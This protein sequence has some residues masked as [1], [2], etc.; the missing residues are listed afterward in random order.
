MYSIAVTVSVNG[1]TAT[2]STTPAIAPMPGDALLVNHEWCEVVGVS[3]ST[4]TLYGP[5]S[6]GN[7]TGPAT[8]LQCASSNTTPAL[9]LRAEYEAGKLEQ[10]LGSELIDFLT[11]AQSTVDIHD[12]TLDEVIVRQVDSAASLISRLPVIA[13]IPTPDA[14]PRASSQGTI[15][16]DWFNTPSLPIKGAGSSVTSAAVGPVPSSSIKV[17]AATG[18]NIVTL[19]PNVDRPSVVV[20]SNQDSLCLELVAPTQPTAESLLRSTEF[21]VLLFP[22]VKLKAL[23]A[24]NNSVQALE[25]VR[26]ILFDRSGGVWNK[27]SAWI[28]RFVYVEGGFKQLSGGWSL[29]MARGPFKLGIGPTDPGTGMTADG[30]TA[31]F[32]VDPAIDTFDMV[33]VDAFFPTGQRM[34]VMDIAGSPADK[35]YVVPFFWGEFISTPP[36]GYQAGAPA[37]SP[38]SA[39][40]GAQYSAALASDDFHPGSIGVNTTDPAGSAWFYTDHLYWQKDLLPTPNAGMSLEFLFGR[41][42]LGTQASYDRALPNTP[43]QS[44][45]MCFRANG[46]GH[47]G[48]YTGA[49]D[50]FGVGMAAADAVSGAWLQMLHVVDG[51]GSGHSLSLRLGNLTEST[52]DVVVNGPLIQATDHDPDF[53]Q[54][55]ILCVSEES[56]GQRAVTLYHNGQPGQTVQ[57]SASLCQGANGSVLFGPC[58]TPPVARANGYYFDSIAYYPLAL[59][60]ETVATH[61]Q[62]AF[63]GIDIPSGSSG[64]TG[65]GT[66]T[67]ATGVRTRELRFT[68]V[69]ATDN[70]TLGLHKIAVSDANGDI[71][72]GATR[73]LPVGSWENTS[74]GWFGPGPSNAPFV[75]EYRL[76]DSVEVSSIT[77]YQIGAG[78]NLGYSQMLTMGWTLEYKNAVGT[79]VELDTRS[80]ITWTKRTLNT[81]IIGGGSSSLSDRLGFDPASVVAPAELIGPDYSTLQLKDVSNWG[82]E[83]LS[84]GGQLRGTHTTGKWYFEITVDDIMIPNDAQYPRAIEVT[85]NSGASYATGVDSA[86]VR[87]EMDSDGS[88]NRIVYIKHLSILGQV[89]TWFANRPDIDIAP[90]STAGKT[91]CV[92]VDMSGSRANVAIGERSV[93]GQPVKWFDGT[94]MTSTPVSMA[95]TPVWWAK[96]LD[97]SVPATARVQITNM[98]A[99]VRVNSGET[100]P[101]FA[102]PTGTYGWG[103]TG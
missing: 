84:R 58:L 19:T 73:T 77:D 56:G 10:K 18:S 32:P 45:L 91:I 43:G 6:G 69:P 55:V 50:D 14:I 30:A 95:S 79:W 86:S 26:S 66:G 53:A 78:S 8:L 23:S 24:K 67:G 80:N 64:G 76:T 21:T 33:A 1:G 20:I 57:V 75:V 85:V 94:T 22:A 87:Y 103:L 92:L 40:P 81:Y 74:V 83:Y 93:S 100:A 31:I 44:V 99:T 41:Y 98:Q 47:G 70:N 59:T 16:V 29:A 63:E 11:T 9:R 3:G 49:A 4:L 71:L 102:V 38:D 101:I 48:S 12:Y 7:Y 25:G 90:L 36:S 28:M 65:T 88:I 42:S 97:K 39:L 5:Y 61:Y 35:I 15:D 34:V 89:I 46:S 62:T 52:A 51:T 60:A 13:T 2:L 27:Y 72:T 82:I 37:G 54:H 96:S 17:Q 68:F